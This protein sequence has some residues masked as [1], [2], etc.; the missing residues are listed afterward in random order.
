M[1]NHTGFVRMLHPYTQNN[2]T[3]HYDLQLNGGY[4]FDDVD[5]IDPVISYGI[6]SSGT[7][8]FVF[9]RA[10]TDLIYEDYFIPCYE[11][12]YA[13]NADDTEF[14]AFINRM[15]QL[16]KKSTKETRVYNGHNV[17]R[18]RVDED[19][20]ENYDKETSNCFMFTGELVEAMGDSRFTDF[21]DNHP[22]QHYTSEN[23]LSTPIYRALWGDVKA[24]WT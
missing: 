14:D 15:K 20:F 12:R 18:Y 24:T 11:Y 16:R 9:D 5:Y 6:V 19:A 17:T 13:V 4:N 7:Y 3:G 1:A 23:M 22:W 10:V 2:P 21:V 8:I